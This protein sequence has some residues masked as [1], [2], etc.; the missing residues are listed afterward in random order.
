MQLLDATSAGTD[1]RY[2]WPS[3]NEESFI[4]MDYKAIGTDGEHYVRIGFCDRK[5]YG[6]VRR[7]V[8]LWIDDHPHAEF[9]GADDFKQSGEVLSEIK[10]PGNKGE[11]MCRYPDEPVPERYAGLPIIGLPTRVTGPGV[12]GAWAIIANIAD[13]HTMTV[14]AA[15]RRVER[16]R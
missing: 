4:Y 14:L 13:H 16:L 5:T 8:V 3:G 11:R 15:L 10:V 6:E 12:H 1:Y 7:R 2:Q 9:V